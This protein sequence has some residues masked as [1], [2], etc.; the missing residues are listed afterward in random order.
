MDLYRK[1]VSLRN[2]EGEMLTLLPE[3]IDVIKMA[4]EL[5]V[6]EDSSEWAERLVDQIQM[7]GDG[8]NKIIDSYVSIL[9]LNPLPNEQPSLTYASVVYSDSNGQEYVLNSILI[10]TNSMGGGFSF[11][12]RS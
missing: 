9:L 3:L 2:I 6:T 5:G 11:S 12:L 10:Q 7:E 8:S 4:N 1:S